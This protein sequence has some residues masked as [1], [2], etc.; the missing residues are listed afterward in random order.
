MERPEGATSGSGPSRPC[1][2]IIIVNYRTAD[3]TSR[4]V[5]KI[6]EIISETSIEIIVVDN[7]SGDGSVEFLRE[8]AP[9]TEIIGL[10]ENLGYGS[11]MNRGSVRARG[12]YLLIM[13]SDIM[14]VSDFLSEMIAFYES[15]AMGAV[16]IRLIE[17]D[18]TLQKTFGIFPSPLLLLNLEMEVL[19]TQGGR[20][21]DRYSTIRSEHPSTQQADWVTGALMLISLENYRAIGGFDEDFFMYYEDVDLCRRL[22]DSG[23]QNFFW[24]EH[25]A[26]HGWGATSKAIKPKAM[27]FNF[28]R[29]A[30]VES[31]LRYV[32]K[33]YASLCGAF[34]CGLRIFFTWEWIRRS[35]KA[36]LASND[37][38]T[39]LHQ[40]K[41]AT[42]HET[43]KRLRSGEAS[44]APSAG[45]T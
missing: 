10:E 24:A 21:T 11:A 37:E 14:I 36:R 26:I 8:N 43:L 18:G 19:T 22:S 41:A 1:V 5:S 20:Y 13:N 39:N 7:G 31:E 45:G 32:Q 38:K 40:R 4:C 3:M 34:R 44:T 30:E 29:V 23:L 27:R 42:A 16:G 25:E 15:G 9:D 6:R 33:Y 35:F 12:R 28:L 2:S 17:P